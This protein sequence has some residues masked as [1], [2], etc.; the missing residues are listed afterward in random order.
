MRCRDLPFFVEETRPDCVHACTVGDIAIV[1]NLIPP[2][3]YAT[4]AAVVLRQPK[5]KEQRLAA[6]WGRMA[7]S[8][9]VGRSQ[10][11]HASGPVV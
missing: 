1:L 6:V 4:L 2:P 11:G 5:R 7:Y 9:A 3:D 8:T 10:D